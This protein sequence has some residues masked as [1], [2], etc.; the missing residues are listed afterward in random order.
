M[1]GAEDEANFLMKSYCGTPGYM[2]PEVVIAGEVCFPFHFS[3]VLFF[4]VRFC[5]FSCDSRIL[6]PL[7]PVLPL[8]TPVPVCPCLP[9]TVTLQTGEGYD[10]KADIYSLGC[11]AYI[12]L[13]GELPYDDDDVSRLEAQTL[14]GNLQFP[15]EWWG[16]TSSPFH[17]STFLSFF[18][19][20]IFA[21]FCFVVWQSL[22]LTFLQS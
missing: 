15:A 2:A 22:F 7:A 4:F 9:L 5:L 21:A 16:G 18:S 10:C 8:G 13:T 20:D 3:S 14:E 6:L 1:F 17:L 12:L 19:N 11:I